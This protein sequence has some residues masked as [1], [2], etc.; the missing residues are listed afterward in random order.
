M[1]KQYW[2]GFIVTLLLSV[3][4][5]LTAYPSIDYDWRSPVNSVSPIGLSMGGVNQIYAED[6]GVAEENPALLALRN[7]TYFAA[8]FKSKRMENSS[9]GDILVPNYLL[10]K[11][12]FTYYAFSGPKFAASF[13][14]IINKRERIDTSTNLSYHDLYLNSY[15]VSLAAQ[16]DDYTKLTL[17]FNLKFIHGRQVYHR[18]RRT[19]QDLI[20]EEFIDDKEI[21]RAHV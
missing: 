6:F 20:L 13:Q 2:K 3:N 7:G 11:K 4:V 14:P 16:D 18:F 1:I 10:K 9:L 5:I 8:T 17:G 21:G 12:Q 19:G 15:T